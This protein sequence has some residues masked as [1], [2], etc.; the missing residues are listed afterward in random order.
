MQRVRET[1]RLRLAAV[2]FLLL[3]VSLAL[4][5]R[6][7][8]PVISGDSADYLMA[9]YNLAQHGVFSQAAQDMPSPG[10]GR[11]PGYGVF[12]AALM[13]AGTPLADFTP[14][15][16]DGERTAC[17]PWID[18]QNSTYSDNLVSTQRQ[19]QDQTYYLVVPYD[20]QQG[21]FQLS[22]D[23]GPV[24]ESPNDV[25]PPAGTT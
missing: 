14:R 3:A 17:A 24:V 19:G 20:V 6:F 8:A 10:L 23:I 11:E 21:T 12:L 2:A 25:V 13:R 22:L 9:A 4:H 18:S 5:A 1:R 16:L 7:K 15:C